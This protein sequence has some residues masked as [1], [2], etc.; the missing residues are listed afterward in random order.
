VRELRGELAAGLIALG[1][2]VVDTD[3]N[4]VLVEAT[5][6]RERLAPSGVVVR[7][8][9]SFGMEGVARVALPPPDALDRVLGAFAD[10][11][12]RCPT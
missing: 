3:S 5:G 4:W 2:A 9:A 11:A 12:E 8:C 6:L 1:Y 7:D 10:V